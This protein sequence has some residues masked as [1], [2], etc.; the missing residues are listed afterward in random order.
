[1]G[2]GH[3]RKEERSRRSRGGGRRDEAGGSK[4]KEWYI[5]LSLVSLFL[6]MGGLR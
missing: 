2:Q 4:M 1:M 6:E 5:L 3:G